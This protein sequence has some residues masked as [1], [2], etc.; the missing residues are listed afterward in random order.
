[1]ETVTI[2]DQKFQFRCDYSFPEKVKNEDCAGIKLGLMIFKDGEQVKWSD[3][4]NTYPA[5]KIAQFIKNTIN[6]QKTFYWKSV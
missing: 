5:E 4:K 3:F 6:G 1:M 2:N